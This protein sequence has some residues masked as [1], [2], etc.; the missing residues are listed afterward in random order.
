MIQLG[1]A[2]LSG[3]GN[4]IDNDGLPN[5]WENEYNLDKYDAS[6]LNLDRDEDDLTISQ[7]YQYGTN[8]NEFSTVGDGISDGWK[9]KH[10]LNPIDEDL[11]TE[12]PDED[13]LNNLGEFKNGT[14]PCN[15]DSDRDGYNDGMEVI[16][17]GLNPLDPDVDKDGLIDGKDED[18]DNMSNWFEKNIS[19]LYDPLVK[20]NRYVILAEFEWNSVLPNWT[21]GEYAIQYNFFNRDMKIPAENIYKI[22]HTQITWDIND[23]ERLVTFFEDVS[24][25]L[26]N[27]VNKNDFLFVSYV[28][29][30]G[31][32]ATI[33]ESINKQLNKIQTKAQCILVNSCYSG[34]SLNYFNQT[35]IPRVIITDANENQTAGSYDLIDSIYPSIKSE[36]IRVTD[37]RVNFD[38]NINTFPDENGNKFVSVKEAFDS[39][40]DI[41]FLRKNLEIP[42]WVP[43]LDNR[44]PQISDKNN[45]ANDLYFGEYM[46]DN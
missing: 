18:G 6:D 36:K 16:V 39:A 13:G 32:G 28:R 25:N 29:H 38:E 11:S 26:S 31:K 24:D 9:V 14:E 12:D 19:P 33:Y 20:N 22:N 34:G 21:K 5:A 41:F 1:G 4:D 46:V 23:V 3:H 43:P 10:D 30:G 35:S 7:E 17:P 37:T 42:N 2:Y 8:P 15:P 40:R 44:I 45:I 27:K